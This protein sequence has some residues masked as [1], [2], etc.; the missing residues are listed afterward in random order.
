MEY[1]EVG[2]SSK[3]FG[4][5]GELKCNFTEHYIEDVLNAPALF[6]YINGQYIPYFKEEL[7]FDNFF[8][9]K[10]ED[11]HSKEDTNPLHNKPIYLRSSDINQVI[12]EDD[13]QD[14]IG[15]S[16]IDVNTGQNVGM[17]IEIHELPE[18]LL[19]EVEREGKSVF[20]PLHPKLIIKHDSVNKL[21]QMTLADGLLDL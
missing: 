1:I 6:F 10:L 2:Y 16:I 18:Q 14:W 13:N 9:L 8:R 3:S 21:I 19:A 20:I 11:I 5:R 17:I 4:V 15:Y 12:P 7:I